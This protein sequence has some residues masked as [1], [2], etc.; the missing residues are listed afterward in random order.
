M[1]QL[2]TVSVVSPGFFGLNTQDSSVT[3]SSNFALAADNCIIDK[4]GRLGARKGWEQKTTDGVDELSNLNIE[5]LAEHVN[6]DDTTVTISAGNQKLFTGGVD[7]VLTDVTP[8]GYTITA[9]NW[10]VATLND[11]ALIV[12]EAH[13]TLVYTESATPN[14]QKLVDYTGVAQAYGTSYPRDVVAAYGRFWAHDGSTVYWTTDIADT[15]F[16]AFAGGTSGFL[17][18]A[19]V[20]PNNVDTVTAIAAHNDFLIIFCSRNIVIYSGASDPLNTF[21]LSDVIAGVGCVARDS[22]QSTGGDLIFLSDTGVRSLGRLLQEKSLPMRDLTKNVRD[23]LREVVATEFALSGS[24]NKVRSAYSEVNAFY[25]LSFPSTS[26]VYCLDMRQALEDGSSRVTT[27]SVKTTAFLRTRTRDLLLGKQNG[28]GLYGG[29]VDNTIQYRMKYS[30]NF[31]DMDNSSMTKMVKKVSI[32]VIGGSG[33]DFVIKTGYDYLGA[34]FSYPFTINEGVGF[35]FTN[36]APAFE[37]PTYL[38]PDDVTIDPTA[39]NSAQ[40]SLAEF[41]A[42]VLIDRVNAQVQGSGK[43]IQI[44]FEANVEGSE[45]SVQKLDMFV[46]TGRIS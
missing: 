6:A 10:K 14:L 26:T 19:A 2:Q 4:F 41:T 23:D 8:V 40:F 5:M 20:L 42:G 38:V 12:Q 33:Q 37:A 44:G 35:E 16:P 32:T 28:I 18:I 27:W 46:K 9:N 29:Y 13:E 30:S 43:V 17:N 25:L 36:P 22:V 31:M 3:L 34:N 45:I 11:H 7:A 39:T 24:Y 1:K 21:K 15:A